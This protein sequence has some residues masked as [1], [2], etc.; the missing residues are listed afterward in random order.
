MS[1]PEVLTSWGHWEALKK[2]QHCT[3]T[4][5]FWMPQEEW[6]LGHAQRAGVVTGE[7]IM[8]GVK[9]AAFIM[10]GSGQIHKIVKDWVIN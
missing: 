1:C 6:T 10:D 4:R 9:V 7:I 3:L 5:L 8:V 2:R